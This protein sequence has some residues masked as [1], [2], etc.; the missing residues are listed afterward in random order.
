MK[1]LHADFT[2]CF[3]H[4]IRDQAMVGSVLGCS[5]QCCIGMNGTGR[6]RANSSGYNKAYAATG[7]LA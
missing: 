7:T 1:Y 5:H 6:I 4:G 3:M 2:T